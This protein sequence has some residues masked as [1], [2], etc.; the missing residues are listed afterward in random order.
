[1]GMKY[2]KYILITGIGSIPSLVLDVGLG[3]ITM[4]TSWLISIIVFVVIIVLLIL[5]YKYKA[6]IFDKVN[7]YIRKTKEKAQNQ[8]GNYN[9]FIYWCVGSGVYS[10][11]KTKMKIKLKNNVGKLQKPCIVLCNHGS[12]YD[13]VY[14]GKLLRKEKPHFVVARMYF[15]HKWLNRILRG[16][17]AF[18]KSMFTADV[19]SSKNCLKVI[20]GGGVL[21]MMPEARLS[22]VGTFEDIQ[23]TTFKFIQKMLTICIII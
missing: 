6:Q 17:G 16:T 12:F 22:T 18:P 14:A 13:F 21:T 2:H 4:S 8:V 11:I 5:M 23:D 15:H 10:F 20:N 19:E 9:P 7:K 1:M 3:H